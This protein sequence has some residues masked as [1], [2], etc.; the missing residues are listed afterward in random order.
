MSL[1][2]YDIWNYTPSNGSS[3][4]VLIYWSRAYYVI[5]LANVFVE[6]MAEKGTAVVG[7]ALSK[8]IWV[9]QGC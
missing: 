8:N 9:K 7:D 6:G 1:P 2:I 3:N 5:N 4:S